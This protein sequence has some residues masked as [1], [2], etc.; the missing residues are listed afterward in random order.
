MG[1]K[2]TRGGA[3]GV[4]EGSATRVRAKRIRRGGGAPPATP[5]VGG[6]SV[7]RS[8]PARGATT[9]RREVAPAGELMSPVSRMQ[10][11]QISP[12]RSIAT[13]AGLHAAGRATG[14]D[15]G[16][17]SE[18]VS[19]Q[20]SAE[21]P[22]R[23]DQ[24]TIKELLHLVETLHVTELD[25]GSAHGPTKPQMECVLQ[26]LG[27]CAECL[28]AE[29]YTKAGKPKKE[30]CKSVLQRV[31]V[32][33]MKQPGFAAEMAQKRKD[34]HAQRRLQEWSPQVGRQH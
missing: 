22:G 23:T 2:R 11:L 26:M 1:P 17:P 27:G 24:E 9:T 30:L 13:E 14:D 15:G 3:D 6:D 33:K 32:A 10:A 5:S 8:T 28:P 21:T 31:L 25:A 29:A 4:G 34:R 19:E 7:C 16:G 18:Q 20:V 12:Q